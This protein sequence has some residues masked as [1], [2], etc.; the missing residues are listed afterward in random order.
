MTT[1]T[2]DRRRFIGTIMA[3]AGTLAGL[4]PV[5]GARAQGDEPPGKIAY[6]KDG[7]IWEWSAGVKPQRLVEDGHAADPAWDPAG[8][9][10]LYVRDGGSFSDLVLVNPQTGVNRTLTDNESPAQKGSP[11]YVNGCSWAL[12]PS[13]NH[14]DV[15]CFISDSGASYGEMQLWVLLPQE[16]TAYQAAHDGGDQGSI[17]NVSVDSSATWCVYTVLAAGGVEG[18]TTYITLRDLN[19][20]ATYPILEG[21]AGAYDAAISPDGEW[22]VAS[23]RDA[24]GASDLWLFNRREET[25]N[26]LTWNEQASGST[27]SPDGEWIAYL[28]RVKDGFEIKA[29]RLDPRTGERAGEAQRL[30]GPEI[31]DTTSG[32]SWAT[33]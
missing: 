4:A 18:G 16:G 22:I 5:A 9:L 13:W 17:E 27:W 30:V 11:E 8:Q 26:Q 33:R 20:G 23:L 3:A 32:L 21:P 31:I 19:T 1:R 10:M 7:D 14:E 24:T 12:D 28:A 15:A 2:T 29:F 25:L 6:I